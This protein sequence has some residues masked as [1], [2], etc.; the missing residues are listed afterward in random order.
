MIV[1]SWIAAAGV[2]SMDTLPTDASC[3]SGASYAI[4]AAM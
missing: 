2:T 3:Y 4:T 1:V